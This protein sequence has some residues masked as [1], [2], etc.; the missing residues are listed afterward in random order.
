[1]QKKQ[2][3]WLEFRK[4]V[5]QELG[6]RASSFPKAPPEVRKEWFAEKAFSS[7]ALKESENLV[8]TNT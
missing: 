8:F 1:M 7:Y 4:T 3:A 5:I 2:D 6:E